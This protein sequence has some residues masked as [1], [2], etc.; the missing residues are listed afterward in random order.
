MLCISAAYAVMGS[1]CLSVRLSEG[2]PI[3]EDCARRIVLLKLTADRHEASGDNCDVGGHL[4]QES[5]LC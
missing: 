3:V 2:I 5:Y 4:R 1:V